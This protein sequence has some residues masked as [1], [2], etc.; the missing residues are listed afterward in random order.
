MTSHQTPNPKKDV[1]LCVT[2][3][4]EPD[5]PDWSADGRGM[6]NVRGLAELHRRLSD[7]GAA[8]TWLVSHAVAADR[9]GMAALE[10]VA[11]LGGGEIGAHLHP[12]EVPG[13]GEDGTEW[14]HRLAGPV[15]REK[16]AALT[17]AIAG[18][19]PRP[20]SF[21]AGRFGFGPEV[22][23]ALAEAGYR[24]DSSVTPYVSWRWVGGPDF[25][26]AA[27]GPQSL[28]AGPAT[29]P[30]GERLVE[31]PVSI[32]PNIGSGRGLWRWWLRVASPE[33]RSRRGVLQTLYRALRLVRPV[34]LRPTYLT[35]EAMTRLAA[36]IAAE[37]RDG[38]TVLVMMFHSNEVTVGTSP[39][40]RT[41][42]Q[43]D[44]LL[45]RIRLFLEEAGRRNYD[46]ATLSEAAARWK[47]EGTSA[48]PCATG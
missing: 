31:L 29:E 32:R 4:T 47:R 42:A 28:G 20:V 14:L 24:V 9:T 40:V 19:L 33:A 22:E 5:N 7:W 10:E 2:I 3:D 39:Y 38:P 6:E 45:S 8:P 36:R 48:R 17:D 44:E 30:G 34:W 21:R 27:D 13:R 1:L 37:P 35:A 43:R 41:E 11:R 25:T 26:A 23:A 16:L 12:R 46:G 15:L 18:H